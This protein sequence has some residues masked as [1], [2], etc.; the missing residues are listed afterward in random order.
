MKKEVPNSVSLTFLSSD[1]VYDSKCIWLNTKYSQ[2]YASQTNPIWR[3]E[4][5]YGTILLLQV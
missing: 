1:L 3:A 2:T 5:K 4:S